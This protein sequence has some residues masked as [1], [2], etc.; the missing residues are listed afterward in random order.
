MSLKV[1]IIEDE[2]A[3]AQNLEQLLCELDPSLKVLTI[4]KGVQESVTWLKVHITD[5]DLL[6]MDIQLNDG[7][8]L[9][10]FKE[11]APGPPVIFVTA[12]DTFAL[13]AFRVNGI[14]YIL[15]PFQDQQ[16]ANTLQKYKNLSRN[17]GID[18]GAI[19]KFLSVLTS[20]NTYKKSYLVQYQ[21]KLIPVKVSAINWFYTEREVVYAFTQEG[22]RYIV[23][24]TLEKIQEEVDPNLFYRANRQFIVQRD[25]IQNIDFYF[26]GRLIVH[27]L[28]KS[29]EKIIVSKA[30][31]PMFKKWLDY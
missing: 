19:S 30:K 23:E 28:P 20:A 29:H 26:N 10:I 18:M 24:A 7:L 21:E 17:T 5:C 22:R 16:L 27:V 15:K 12:Y 6:F 8:S 2:P 31:S 1:A 3:I 14:D 11:I 13:D 9:D 4:L 25:A